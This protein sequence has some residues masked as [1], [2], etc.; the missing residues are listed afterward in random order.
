MR[1]ATPR[2]PLFGL[3]QDFRLAFRSLHRRPGFAAAAI[4]T[5]ALGIGASTAMFS[6]VYGVS[7]R[8]LAYAAPD[9]IVRIY[10]ANPANGKLEED[11]SEGAFHDWREGATKSIE[12]MALISR[13]STRIMPGSDA[14]RI[15]SMSVSPAFFDVLG[16]GPVLGRGFRPEREYTRETIREV[17]LSFD[18][19][20]RLFA[21]DAGI[22]GRSF[23]ID[24]KD[25]DQFLV[26]GV[27]PAGFRFGQPVDLWIPQMIR[28]PIGRIVRNWRYDR[29]IARLR[30]DATL[31]QAAA[32]L[33]VVAERL[34]RDFPASNSGWTVTVKPLHA[35]IV[36]AFG[37]ATWMLL[38]AVAVV[39]LVACLNV[40]GL[41][42]A[43]AVSRER[44]TAVRVALGAD[45]WRVLRLWLAEATL[46]GGCGLALGLLLAW[47]GVRALRA[48]A[49]PGIP[50]IDEVALDG[51]SLTASILSA[52]LAVTIFTVAP[53]RRRSARHPAA[54]LR[55]G[56]AG[57]GSRSRLHTRMAL[58]MAQCAGAAALVI[59]AVMLTR[60]FI[61]LTSFDLGFD[62]AGVLS[63]D[64]S[65][66]LPRQPERPWYFLVEWSDRLQAALTAAPQ[67]EAAAVTTQVPLGPQPFPS[68]LAR[69]R[70]KAATDVT[71]WPGVEH[72][73]TDGY[74]QV[75]GV[76]LVAGRVF[77][78]SDRFTEAQVN[79]RG[80]TER[81]VAIVSD[82]TAKT[83]W[84]GRSAVG[85]AIW[86][87]DVDNVGWREVVGVVEDMQFHAVGEPPA[88]H[89]FV[90]W[91]QHTTGRPRLVVKAAS[92]QP[93]SAARL[94]PAVREIVQ[95]VA[96]G[97]T[98]DQVLPMEV[99][100]ARATAQPRFTS[101]TVAG[102]GLLALLL[103]AV[104]IYGTLAYLVSAGTREIGVRLALGAPRAAIV[105]GVLWRGLL[106]ALAGGL[107]GLAL[108][109]A[110][111][112][113]F[114]A[115]LFQIAPLDVAS[116]GGGALILAVVAIAAALGP[117]MRASRVDP[118]TALRSE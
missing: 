110:L 57:Q 75:M 112:R 39:L 26:V 77:D 52:L 78:Q 87:P 72:I 21:G 55:G 82:R 11:V 30:P 81:G 5:L 68:S 54:G 67:I 6:V 16:V 95:R 31:D 14:P 34:A 74:F 28:P 46:V 98:V 25:D 115:L 35:A 2:Q 4:A 70:G 90:P 60:S 73:V 103:A 9:R 93:G 36:G 17:V 71:R 108:A 92:T 7:L 49:P 118:V 76:R 109:M 84:P 18:A 89:V 47:S 114:R 64:V 45:G 113:T 79:W 10:E 3:S 40:G 44:E 53:L 50:R 65:P 104:G 48:A 13:V 33:R 85:E 15:S 80:K 96:P 38:A 63:L 24:E 20:Q 117:A 105:T 107:V 102:F 94:A 66:P 43:R 1:S 83:L 8:P 27:M 91:T 62:P 116:L 61:R 32:E 37:R 101:R 29:V 59:L 69:G 99:L 23:R 100:V 86:L 106:P 58:T 41:L 97:S 42:V 12:S 22:V 88:L 111:A 51:P 19:W 56:A